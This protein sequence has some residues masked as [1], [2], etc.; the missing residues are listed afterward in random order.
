[1]LIKDQFTEQLGKAVSSPALKGPI[2]APPRDNRGTREEKITQTLI[3][4]KLLKLLQTCE[5]LEELFR[6]GN[7]AGHV[8]LLLGISLQPSSRAQGKQGT[9]LT[10]VYI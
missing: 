5:V 3:R 4:L 1:M 7:L 10:V 9:P 6:L 8:F 2:T